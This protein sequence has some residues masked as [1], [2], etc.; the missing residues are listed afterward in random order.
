MRRGQGRRRGLVGLEQV[1]QVRHAVVCAQL[2]RALVAR[3]LVIGCVFR[4]KDV[5]GASGAG[6]ELPVPSVSGRKRRVEG[7]Y[8]VQ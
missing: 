7:I 5:E 6:E 1:M 8:P 3:R 4:A 2:A